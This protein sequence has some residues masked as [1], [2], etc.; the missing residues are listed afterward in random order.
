MGLVGWDCRVAA[1]PA[2]LQGFVATEEHS[3]WVVTVDLD[4]V[5]VDF[6]GFD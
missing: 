2:S 1:D 4:L 3:D 6:A 5:T